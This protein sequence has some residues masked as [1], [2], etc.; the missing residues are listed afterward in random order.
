[1][2]YPYLDLKERPVEPPTTPPRI[3]AAHQVSNEI[4]MLRTGNNVFNDQ[5][6]ATGARISKRTTKPIAN[7]Y[8]IA[9]TPL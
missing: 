1:M 9:R 2:I 7:R 3:K 5:I 8:F 6:V 4:G